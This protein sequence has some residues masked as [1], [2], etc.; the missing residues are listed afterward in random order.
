MYMGS[1]T[2]RRTK[3]AEHVYR[4]AAEK[5][6][7][8]RQ[9]KRAK[10]RETFEECQK[11]VGRVALEPEKGKRKKVV[12]L[13][14][15]VANVSPLES[16]VDESPYTGFQM[17]GRIMSV[18]ANEYGITRDE[19]IAHRRAQ[20]V[21]EPRHICMFLA[22]EMTNKS[23]PQ[24]GKQMGGRDHTTILYGIDKVKRQISESHVFADKVATLR[25]LVIGRSVEQSVYFGA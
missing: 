5:Q 21:T 22:K 6:E 3:L 1:S 17:I 16:L 19:M 11:L 13:V 12:R 7:L 9:A 25:E 14:A 23:L 15:P 24:I 18:V 20:C 10:L 2:V 8:L 4:V